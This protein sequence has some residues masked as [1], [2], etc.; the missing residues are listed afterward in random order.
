MEKNPNL[1]SLNERLVRVETEL[2]ELKKN[3]EE[4]TK[5]FR[6]LQ[7]DF[8]SFIRGSFSSLK[9]KNA[10]DHGVFQSQINFNT[11]LSWGV[12]VGVILTLLVSIL[13]YLK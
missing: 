8:Y 4:H 1:K 12:F 10:R 9:E 5:E 7:D 11:K 2:K 3:I 6:R 13:S